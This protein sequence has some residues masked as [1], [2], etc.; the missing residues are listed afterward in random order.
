MTFQQL[1][2]FCNLVADYKNGALGVL[3][4]VDAGRLP[5]DTDRQALRRFIENGC[6]LIYDDDIK[7]AGFSDLAQ[8]ASMF[9]QF[10]HNTVDAPYLHG[11]FLTATN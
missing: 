11:K 10:M 4:D 5:Q 6:D 9:E 7:E 8:Y 1:N 3:R 2:H